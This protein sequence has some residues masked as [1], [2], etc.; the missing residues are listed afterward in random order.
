MCIGSILWTSSKKCIN[1]LNLDLRDVSIGLLLELKIRRVFV[2]MLR[3]Y[4]G[5]VVLHP[6][7][8][9]EE[10]KTL[11]QQNKKIINDYEG[12]LHHCD[13][14]GRRNLANPIKNIKTGIFFHYTFYANNKAITELERTLRINSFVLKFLH[15]H[16][17]K[18]SLEK[19]LRN[20]YVRLENTF[21]KEKERERK[22]LERKKEIQQRP[23]GVNTE[24]LKATS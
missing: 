19:Y 3:P 11:F 4:E 18:I 13:T 23:L 15:T 14:W 1:S 17:G 5:V 12:S 22:R 10:Q 6:D 20:Y 21:L 16:L 8:T 24:A 7:T 9:L 2:E